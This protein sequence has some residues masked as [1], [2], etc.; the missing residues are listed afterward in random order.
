MDLPDYK[1]IMAWW[2]AFKKCPR[3]YQI[4][5][6]IVAS[7]IVVF[8]AAWA[9]RKIAG[10]QW[11]TQETNKPQK[12]QPR[13]LIWNPNVRA[14]STISVFAE[15]KSADIPKPLK[16][17]YDGIVFPT[18]TKPMP[19]ANPQL[20]HITLF[21]KNIP[22]HMLNE[23]THKLRFAFWGEEFSDYS[24][25]VISKKA[26]APVLELF[27][28]EVTKEDPNKVEVITVNTARGFLAAIKPNRVIKLETGTYYLS[29][30][31]GMKSKN[32]AWIKVYDGFEPLVHSVSNLK[33]IGEEGV[34]ILIEPRY[35]WVLNFQN[36]KNIV[37]EN[38]VIGHAGAGYCAG[39]VLSFI[40]CDNLEIK[41]SLL[42]GSGT[43]GIQLDKVDNLEFKNSTIRD[44]TYEL[45]GIYNSTS[46]FLESS[47]LENTGQFN[48]ISI[49]ESSHN[50]KFS[51]CLIQ[52]N[53]TGDYM[54]Y[55]IYI[56]EKAGPVSLIG[57]QIKSNKTKMFTNAIDRL[58][59]E[60]TVFS[61]NSFLDF[62]DVTLD[63]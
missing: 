20:W 48:L 60:K 10:L 49:S 11:A 1:N 12:E 2:R 45:I 38:L 44:C 56:G 16:V 17:E 43:T 41:D 25:I 54:P 39:G 4:I 52:N 40:G 28:A 14:G 34:K 15:N 13:F 33:I 63:E 6:V 9:M 23:G 61:D 37:L 7:I 59:I 30:A 22:E 19:K 26:F 8:V 62:Q 27:E 18:L 35:A 46:I 58:T 53:W 24:E 51:K 5:I 3:P 47:V 29:I 21:D 42:F 32:L 57:C 50:I 55:L 36:C 31:A